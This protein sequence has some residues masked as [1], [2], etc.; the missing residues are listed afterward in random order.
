MIQKLFSEFKKSFPEVKSKLI[1]SN[2]KSFMFSSPITKNIYFNKKQ[3]TDFKFSKNAIK[4]VLAHEFSHQL[5]YNEMNI[6]DRLLFKL[7]YKDFE[8]R[9][10]KEREADLIAIK[11]GFGDELI[12]LNKESKE[13]FDKKRF[14]NIKKVHLSVK[15]IK[16]LMN[17]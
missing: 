11:R 4:G 8:F 7:R 16:E 17:C 3:F 9:R 15:E 13:K 2:K 14:N 10:K 1:Q 5:I 6:I 12:K